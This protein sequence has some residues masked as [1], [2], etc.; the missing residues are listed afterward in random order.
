[1]WVPWPALLDEEGPRG[2]PGRVRVGVDMFVGLV[3]CVGRGGV[4]ECDATR[5][6]VGY[7]LGKS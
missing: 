5:S 2:W 7:F 6:R 1:M 4:G 3:R